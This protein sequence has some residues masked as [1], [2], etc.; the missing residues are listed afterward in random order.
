MLVITKN[1]LNQLCI[2]VNEKATL[3]SPTY[4]FIFKHK[5]RNVNTPCILVNSS[6]YARYDLFPFTE[7]TSAT[8]K[9]TGEYVLTVYEQASAVNTDP[10][11][12][13]AVVHIEQCLVLKEPIIIKEYDPTIT[14]N[15][16]EF[17]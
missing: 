13:L 15:I 11:L 5:E 8:L 7:G 9:Y 4:L 14:R 6:S 12:A 3:S 2:S 17:S 16:Y 10:D 1:Q